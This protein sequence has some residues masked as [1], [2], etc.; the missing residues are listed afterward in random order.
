MRKPFDQALSAR[1]EHKKKILQDGGEQAL[2]HSLEDLKRIQ[3][4]LSRLKNNSFGFC[5][6]CGLQI[7]KKRLEIYPEA[8]RCTPCQTE[9]EK[10]I[11]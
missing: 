10:S 5:L 1:L 9:H 3:R 6:S 8:E 7:S 4:A 11:N 2:S